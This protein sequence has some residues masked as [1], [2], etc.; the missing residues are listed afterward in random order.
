VW[1]YGQLC[2][3]VTCIEYFCENMA[4]CVKIWLSLDICVNIWKYGHLCGNF[5]FIRYFCERCSMCENMAIFEVCAVSWSLVFSFW[6][7]VCFLVREKGDTPTECVSRIL[8]KGDMPTECASRILV[9]WDTRCG[10]ASLFY[11]TVKTLPTEYS[12]LDPSRA[13]RPLNVQH[14]VR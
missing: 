2:E 1:K 12:P 4:I 5:T 14:A 8:V 10:G 6:W 11:F 3:N 7:S 13:A 9:K